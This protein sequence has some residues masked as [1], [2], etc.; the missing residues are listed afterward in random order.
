MLCVKVAKKDGQKVK[1]VLVSL[2]VLARGYRSPAEDGFLYFPVTEKVE[3]Y[4]VVEKVCDKVKRYDVPVSSFDQVGDIVILGDEADPAIAE[5]LIKRQSVAVVLQKVGQHHGEF[6]TQDLRWLAG[7]KR[8]ETW[9]KENGVRMR[10]DVERCYFSPRLSTERKRVADLVKDGEKVLV[11]FSGVGPYPLVIAKHAKPALIVA[12]EK[13]PVAHQYA[14]AN[15]KKYEIIQCYNEDVKAFVS[16]EKFDRVLMPLPKSAEEFLDVVVRLVK[17][18]GVIH[19]YDFVQESEWPV[20]CLEKIRKK[21]KK[22]IV[23]AETLCGK[24][25]PGKYRVCVDFK[26]PR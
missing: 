24:Y 14:V 8:K 9:Y 7:E 20:Q 23:L 26:I 10:L 6:R 19:F 12:V 25:A 16:K 18:D 5:T 2:G 4:P 21:V 3:G 17:E 22:I 15:C 13:N 11:L 1:E